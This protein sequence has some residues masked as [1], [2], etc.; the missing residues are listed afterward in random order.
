LQALAYDLSQTPHNSA[1][2]RPRAD[3]FL[4]LFT[5][6]YEG[7]ADMSDIRWIM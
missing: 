1:R 4:S 6:R 7:S 5:A 2:P 3:K